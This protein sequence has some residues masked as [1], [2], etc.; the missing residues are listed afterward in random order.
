MSPLA[1]DG[2]TSD[3]VTL[4]VE[5]A[6]AVRP[7]FG[8]FDEQTAD[9]VIRIC[10]TLDGLPLGI[11]LA[12]ARMAAMSA[13]EVSDRLGDRFRL[14]TG[15]ELGPDRQATLRHAVAWS[16]DLLD[17]DERAILRTA[18]VFSGGFDLPALCAVAEAGDDVEVLR[19]AGLVGAQVARHRPP[20][21]RADPVQPLRDDPGVRR[22]AAG[23]D[24]D[25]RE[26]ARDRHAAYFAGEAVRRWE[27]W[28]GPEWRTQ[29]DW[30]Q[31]ELAN[32][33]SAYR[34]SLDRGQVETATDVAA[35]AA[36]MGFSVE[37]FETIGWAEGVLPAAERADVRRLP[38]LYAAA[39]YA[40][41]V[42]RAEAATAN[43]HRATE[44]EGRPGYESCEPGYATF[45]EALGQVYCGNLDRYVEL[46][47][48]VAALPGR[49]QAYGIAAYVDGLQSSGR[50]EEALQLTESALTAARDLGNPYWLTYTLWIVGLAYSKADPQR[51]LQT[52]DEGVTYLGEHD[53]RFFEGFLA[54]DAALLHTSD[55]QLETALS[56]FGTSIEAFVRSGAVAQLVISLASLPALFER[57]DRP[58]VAQTVL[59]AMTREA[60]S[61]HHVPGLAD[62]GATARPAARPGGVG[63]LR[64]GRRRDGRPRHRVVRPPPDRPRPPCAD[65]RRPGRRRSRRP[66]GPRDAGPAA[67][68]RR[69]DHPRDLRAAVHLGEDRR[70]PH[71]AHLHQARRHQPGRGDPVG[72]RP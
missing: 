50:V 49:G 47:R 64:R 55:G 31:T 32:L 63:A 71:P 36:L 3:A 6:R 37:L 24:G 13:V 11:E 33:R 52:W 19:H 66:D 7:G 39:G 8:I 46:T 9:A 42:G 58:G 54:R 26:A 59:G 60:G 67:D 35:H 16:Y 53:V 20:R 1:V 62:L 68:R 44:L 18:S 27:R 70:Q 56:L 17:D 34:W 61:S 48:E 45:I 23:G 30:V 40:C 5:R 15:P 43:A 22:R 25:E 41:F 14:L 57:L 38:R 72:L 29:V 4:F 21:L 65:G 10:E 69:G 28:N 51:A 2:V 12:A